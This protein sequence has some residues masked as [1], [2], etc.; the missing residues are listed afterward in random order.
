MQYCMALYGII[1]Y[2]TVA[3]RFP[4]AVDQSPRA[5]GIPPASAGTPAPASAGTPALPSASTS[6]PASA[7]SAAPASAGSAA[8]ASAACSLRFVAGE[9]ADGNAP[10][11]KCS[12]CG[13]AITRGAY[14]RP[15]CTRCLALFCHLRCAIGHPC[16]DPGEAERSAAS[17]AEGEHGQL[18]PV[19]LK[20]GVCANCKAHIPDAWVGMCVDCL[21][22]LD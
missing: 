5:M 2:I 12:R 21:D 16:V 17:C 7:G 3:H 22:A 18:P 8:A 20:A 13:I 1:Q 10:I 9:P 11:P 6:A 19:G 14:D 15:E 4:P